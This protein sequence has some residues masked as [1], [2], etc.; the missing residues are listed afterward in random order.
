MAP[1]MPLDVY[2]MALLT[3]IMRDHRMQLLKYIIH[4]VLI[5]SKFGLFFSNIMFLTPTFS[6]VPIESMIKLQTF[7]ARVQFYSYFQNPSMN[8]D[9]VQHNIINSLAVYYIYIDKIY[10]N[11]I[12]EE[13]VTN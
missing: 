1:T 9:T 3:C 6:K 12:D 5:N 8:S 13:N 10:I 2:C 11:S 4:R 7:F